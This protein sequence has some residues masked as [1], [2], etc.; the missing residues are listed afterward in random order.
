V[1]H[2]RRTIARAAPLGAPY[3]SSRFWLIVE[4]IAQDAVGIAI[5]VIE[6]TFFQH[7]TKRQKPDQSQKQA[8]GDQNAQNI[9][10][11]PPYFSRSAFSPTVMDESDMAKA[12]IKG[13]HKPATA[14]GTAKTL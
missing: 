4:I 3:G 2:S 13:E 5:G 9:H 12:A 14:K 7:P 10:R 8:D 1:R 11:P 6:L